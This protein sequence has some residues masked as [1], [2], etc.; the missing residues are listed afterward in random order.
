MVEKT[1]LFF[2]REFRG[3]KKAILQ[4]FE[5]IG[6]GDRA[7]DGTG[8]LDVPHMGARDVNMLFNV[9]RESAVEFRT[10]FHQTNAFDGDDSADRLRGFGFR[11]IRKG[12]VVEFNIRGHLQEAEV[13]VKLLEGS[14]AGLGKGLY[15]NLG[16]KRG[17][18]KGFIKL[19]QNT[20]AEADKFRGIHKAKDTTAEGKR[21]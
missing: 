15:R 20:P 16:R 9:K 10:V 8:S 2:R 7:G 5:E 21:Q 14:G 13:P 17:F 11:F 12:K 4:N 6:H 3:G 19:E 1:G 18:P